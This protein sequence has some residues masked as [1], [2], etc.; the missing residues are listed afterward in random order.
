MVYKFFDKASS[1]SG[2]SSEADYQLAE[3]LHE[4]IFRK[5]K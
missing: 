2:I 3:E 1:G 4:P 5:F